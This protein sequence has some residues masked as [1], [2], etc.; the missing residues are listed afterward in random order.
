MH[1]QAG[2]LAGPSLLA[3]SDAGLANAGLIIIDLPSRTKYLIDTGTD[4]SV[5]PPT[6]KERDKNGASTL[7][8][9]AANGT[10][11]KTYGTRTIKVSLGLRREFH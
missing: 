2:K 7:Q 5:L 1:L 4:I 11:I 10:P 6:Q 8:L 9:L 3:T